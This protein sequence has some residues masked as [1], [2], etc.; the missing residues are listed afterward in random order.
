MIDFLLILLAAL[1]HP[2]YATIYFD[3][4]QFTSDIPWEA[5]TQIRWYG[6][7]GVVT[8]TLT[9]SLTGT[10]YEL[11]NCLLELHYHRKVS[12]DKLNSIR[13]TTRKWIIV[14]A[15]STKDRRLSVE[16]ELSLSPDRYL[17]VG[18]LGSNRTV[19]SIL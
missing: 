7:V 14:P 17:S 15:I 4:L 12:T 3:P 19:V 1:L 8:L 6:Q 9:E 16:C 13:L 11:G 2:A 18:S 5:V 10:K